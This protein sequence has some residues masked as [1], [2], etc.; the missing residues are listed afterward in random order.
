MIGYVR[1]MHFVNI[2]CAIYITV[3]I[4][5]LCMSVCTHINKILLFKRNVFYVSMLHTHFI[6]LL[7]PTNC[8]ITTHWVL[9]M[10][11]CSSMQY[12]TSISWDTAS[13]NVYKFSTFSDESYVN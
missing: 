10:T 7:I 12:K 5:V 6:V 1:V 13:V 8:G 11:L 2:K 4:T 3:L 9:V